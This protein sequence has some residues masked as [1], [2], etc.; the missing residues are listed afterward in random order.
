MKKKPPTLVEH[1]RAGLPAVAG[2]RLEIEADRFACPYCGRLAMIA[3]GPPVR[4]LHEVPMCPTFAELG[5]DG[6]AAAVIPML[7]RE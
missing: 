3:V 7:V 4:S 5:A 1:P 6:Y 2:V